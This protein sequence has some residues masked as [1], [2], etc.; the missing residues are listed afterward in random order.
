MPLDG[1]GP[2]GYL[3]VLATCVLSI[4][5][6]CDNA[7][8]G[9]TTGTPDDTSPASPQDAPPTTVTPLGQGHQSVITEADNGRTFRM[10]IGATAFLRLTSGQRLWDEPHVEGD[11]IE[12]T[13]VYYE[14]DPGYQEWAIQGRSAG[15]AR[16]H[17]IARSN[18]PDPQAEPLANLEVTIVVE[19]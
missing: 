12:L 4:L 5:C 9:R 6:A 18:P 16:I 19:S 15:T 1:C 17:A 13:P 3:L 2:P 14:T 8:N 11:A 7:G 10:S